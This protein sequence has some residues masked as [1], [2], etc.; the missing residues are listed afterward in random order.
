[1]SFVVILILLL[2][3][4]MKYL[5]L[6]FSLLLIVS[7]GHRAESSEQKPHVDL[8]ADRKEL[9]RLHEQGR[10]AH[11]EKN[12]EL[13]V[14]SMA[15]DFTS[16]SNG[17]ISRPKKEDTIQRFQSYFNSVEFLAWDDIS[18]PVI[19]ISQ[20]GTMAHVLVHKRVHLTAKDEKGKKI[21]EETIFAWTSL[22]EKRAGKWLLTAVTSTNEPSKVK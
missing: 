17:K 13:M 18:E 14:T 16:I 4:K 10:K 12:A 3:R 21:E 19:K 11:L 1:M 6:L 9:L 7:I 15:D 22:Y 8:V 2:E 20:D 5:L